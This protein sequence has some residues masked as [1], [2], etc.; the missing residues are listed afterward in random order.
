[1]RRADLPELHFITPIQNVTSIM[2][3]G[4]LCNKK[5]RRLMHSS[6]AMQEIQ[7]KR[8]CKT[9]PGG[10]PL[11][12]YVNLY[13][14]ARNPMMRK[15]ADQH[16]EL[17]ILRVNTAV[18]DMPGAIVTDGNAASGYTV[19]LPSPAGLEMV[20]RDLVFAEYWTDPDEFVQWKKKRI[21]CAEVLV[22]DKVVANFIM[23]AYVSCDE[24]RQKLLDGGFRLPITI[25]A[26]LFFQ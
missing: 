26:H 8:A 13:L 18:M 1:M 6:V 19:F 3:Y 11:H 25:D 23:G 24:A 16:Q 9:I 5:A 22:P 15:L 12:D 21:K 2:R 14:C 4:I 17:C 10:K 20:N 7:D